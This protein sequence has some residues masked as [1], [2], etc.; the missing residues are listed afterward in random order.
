MD[1]SFCVPFDIVREI[2]TVRPQTWLL[3]NKFFNEYA[4]SLLRKNPLVLPKLFQYA[5]RAGSLEK[6]KQFITK[7]LDINADDG[8]ALVEACKNNHMDV[9]EFL[10][11]LEGIDVNLHHRKWHPIEVACE[12]GHTQLVE[13]LLKETK[14]QPGVSSNT[15]IQV[16]ASN[17][18][19]DI[20]KVLLQDPRVNVSNAIMEGNIE[21]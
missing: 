1:V 19:I 9:V 20:V 5:A 14:M 16:A 2:V 8:F 17:G 4:L 7:K 11:Q 21:N 10:L 6:V 13:R 15:A 3:I 12:S 18:H